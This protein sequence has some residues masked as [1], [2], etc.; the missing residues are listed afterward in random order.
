MSRY[1]SVDDLK[2]EFGVAEL[3]RALGIVRSSYYAWVKR[4]RCMRKRRSDEAELLAQIRA[5]YDDSG[6]TYGS[7]RAHA[8]LRMRGY[9]VNHKRVARI[10]AEHNIVGFTGRKGIKTTIPTD[11]PCKIADLIMRDFSVGEPHRRYCGDI[12]YIAT[13]EGV[14]YLAT[15]IDLGSRRC[16][17]WSMSSNMKTR[18]IVDALKAAIGMAGGKAPEIFHSD[19]GAQYTSGE[20]GDVCDH[21]GITQS[22]GAKG[23]CYD[24]AVAESFF[25]TY[26]RELLGDGTR[27]FSTMEEAKVLTTQWI[28]GWYNQKRLHSSLGMLSPMQWE[29]LYADEKLY[30]VEAA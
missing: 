19:R 11:T 14:M 12:S 7:P 1:K 9:R 21:Y 28:E 23:V 29:S 4:E 3:C 30:L 13:G 22:M 8:S 24:N 15:V 26:K 5:I 2:A 16:V 25:G 17:G 20:F 18:L 27:I 10:M 6:G